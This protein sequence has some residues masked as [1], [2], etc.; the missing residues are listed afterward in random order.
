MPSRPNALASMSG[1]TA[2]HCAVDHNQADVL[3]LLCAAPGAAAALALRNEDGRTPLAIAV[4]HGH[5]AFAAVL[6]AHG[7]P[8]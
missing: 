6:R 3:K 7:A 2:L 4:H 8:E 5:D 1:W